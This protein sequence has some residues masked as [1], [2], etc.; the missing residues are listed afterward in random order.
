MENENIKRLQKAGFVLIA[1]EWVNGFWT[2]RINSKEFEAFD[3]RKYYHGS[4]GELGAV[5]E[6]IK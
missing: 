6:D 1:E 3:D 4:I 2:I 5:L